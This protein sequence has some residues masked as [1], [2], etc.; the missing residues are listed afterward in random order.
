MRR[1]S[2]VVSAVCGVALVFASACGKRSI[3][4]T[5]PEPGPGCR[6]SPAPGATPDGPVTFALLDPVDLGRAP[7]ASGTSDRIVFGHLYETLVTVD[8][9]GDVRPCVA[10]S[11]ASEEADRVWTF[12]LHRHARFWD[13][14]SVTAR[15]V[16]ACWRDALTLDTVIDS[17]AA[18]SDRSLRVYLK[19]PHT[20]LPRLLSASVYA[21]TKSS[22]DTGW[23]M[24]SGPY[25]V[26]SVDTEAYPEPRRT[27]TVYP[28]SGISGPVIR[29]VETSADRI[30]D[31]ME[32]TI[33][34]VVT[35]DPAVIEYAASRP[36]FLTAALPWERTYVLLSPSRVRKLGEGLSA[37][38]LSS[39]L[40]DGL[41]RDA[42]RGDAR[43][44]RAPS[45]WDELAG[46]DG[47]AVKENAR[48]AYSRRIVY[49]ASDT[50]ARGLAERIA[51]LSA[52]DTAASLEARTFAQAVP[53]F[54]NRRDQLTAVGLTRDEFERSL[55][56]GDEFAYV[57]ALPRRAP[58][59]CDEAGALIDKAPWLASAGNG[60]TG[61]LIP[62]VDARSHLIVRKDT[63]AVE[64]DGYGAVLVIPREP[65]AHDERG[66]AP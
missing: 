30:R 62:L 40:L 20:Q 13:G 58:D 7:W 54:S 32:S 15:D 48:G 29:F 50:V 26:G 34:A 45:W 12:D 31:G 9:E 39:D 65:Q 6:V 42:V 44:Y 41:A 28:A 56:R 16:A 17:V 2:V 36:G 47:F 14:A 52:A 24:G 51:A 5:A 64:L 33:D 19:W 60:L 55:R 27:I 61:A 11:W 23:L 3:V 59:P 53:D 21:V 43:G 18:V 37:G 35:S 8:C 4:R 66:D 25:R 22:G 63:V 10:A 46:C 49:D 38:T 57:A 1:R